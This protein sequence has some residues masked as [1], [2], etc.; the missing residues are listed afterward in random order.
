MPHHNQY[1]NDQHG[2]LNSN[3]LIATD[4]LLE[5]EVDIP[6]ALA[7]YFAQEKKRVPNPVKGWILIDTGATRTAV[8]ERTIK[9]L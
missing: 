4:P 5:A 3:V 6:Q 1:F 2:K 9:K 8:D 7:D